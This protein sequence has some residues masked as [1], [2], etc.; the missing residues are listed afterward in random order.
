MTV[1]AL[2]NTYLASLYSDNRSLMSACT[3]VCSLLSQV[4]AHASIALS[5]VAPQPCCSQPCPPSPVRAPAS[6]LAQGQL[7]TI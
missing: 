6:Y 2:L 1:G 4:S 3:L 5:P 7:S